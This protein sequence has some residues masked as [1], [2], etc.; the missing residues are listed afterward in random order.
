MMYIKS[1]ETA[2]VYKADFL[3]QFGGW[4]LATEEEYNAYMK[5][6]GLDK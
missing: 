5:K 3:P 4:E 6:M 1:V 2:Q